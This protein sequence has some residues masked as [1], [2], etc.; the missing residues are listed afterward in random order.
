LKKGRQVIG[1]KYKPRS[2]DQSSIVATKIM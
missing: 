2:K 1:S